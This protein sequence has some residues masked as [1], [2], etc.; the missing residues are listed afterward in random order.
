MTLPVAPPIFTS[1]PEEY[2]QE[3][4]SQLV[5]ELET[6][7]KKLNN[8]GSVTAKTV[9]ITDLPTSSV[10]LPSGTLWNDTGTVKVA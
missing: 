1:A 2:D 9:R 5:D 10:G 3:Y 8:I 4:M 6:F 7:I